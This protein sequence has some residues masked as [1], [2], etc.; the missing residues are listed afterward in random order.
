MTDLVG[1]YTDR[2]QKSEASFI[3]Q[4]FN[5]SKSSIK[6]VGDAIANGTWLTPWNETSSH[7]NFTSTA[8]PLM[9]K[10]MYGTMIPYGWAAATKSKNPMMPVIM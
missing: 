3:G 8:L 1:N 2:W 7:D 6:Y 9:V 10:H 5:G 4:L